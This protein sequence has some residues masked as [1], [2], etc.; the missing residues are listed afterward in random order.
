MRRAVLIQKDRED[1]VSGFRGSDAMLHVV[2]GHLSTPCRVLAEV[3]VMLAPMDRANACAWRDMR[4]ST[5][6]CDFC[7]NQTRFE[8][9]KRAWGI[10][11]RV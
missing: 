5:I 1:T 3:S 8:A 9:M 6:L 2:A 11:C 10:G 7:D 4:R